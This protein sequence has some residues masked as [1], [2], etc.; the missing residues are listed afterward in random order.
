MTGR[1]GLAVGAAVGLCLLVMAA[2]GGGEGDA[3]PGSAAGSGTGG[4][5]TAS[6]TG[7]TPADTVDPAPTST[8]DT[9]PTAIPT[10]TPATVTAA[11][12]SPSASTSRPSTATSGTATTGAP[13]TS[14]GPA[15]PAVAL[16]RGPT[17][18]N[19]VALTFDAG[20]D[21]G[22]AARILDVLAAEGIKATFGMTGT[23]AEANPDLVRRM[24]DEGHLLL[25]HTYDHRSFTGFSTGAAALSTAERR[26]ELARAD[27]AV[28][29]ITGVSMAPWFRPP[30][31]DIDASVN[32][33]LGAAGYRWNVLWTVDSLGW[34]GL[35]AA[36]IRTRCLDRAGAG[37][38]Y[39]FHVGSQSQDAVALPDLI[40]GLR[41]RGYGFVR[42]DDLV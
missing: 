39:L 15:A 17:S 3:G 13:A 36:D 9:V 41:D 22:Y 18:R 24:V 6:C 7:A 30:Y 33:D 40:A 21:C 25:N 1:A 23:W 14:G 37:V 42:V 16:Y 31:G 26:D 4:G 10:A 34:K 12:N 27:Q 35:S 5:Q 32:A 19:V 28:A 11:P 38:I 2:C 29:A 8:F 20:S